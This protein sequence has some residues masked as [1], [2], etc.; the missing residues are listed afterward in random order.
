MLSQ[1]R[2][3]VVKGGGIVASVNGHRSVGNVAVMEEKMLRCAKS[4]ADIVGFERTATPCADL[5]R[6]RTE[7]FDGN[8]DQIRR[9]KKTFPG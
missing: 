4:R 3:E 7:G 5:C 9:C 8:R 6:R 2:T 1:W